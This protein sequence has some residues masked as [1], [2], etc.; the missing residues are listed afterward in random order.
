MKKYNFISGLPRSGS[1]L[2]S[3]ILNQNPRFTAG[4]SDPLQAYTHSIIRDTAASVGMSAAVPVEKRADIIRGLF[5]T[6]YKNDNEVCFN[7]NRGWAGD[8]HL[9]ADLFPNFK[10]IVCLRDVPW[11]LDSFEVLNSKNPYTIK[12]LYHHIDTANV[13][14]RTNIL[15]G[16]VPN[17]AGYVSGPVFNARASMFSAQKNQICYVEYDNLAKNPL[18]TMKQIYEF[19]EEPWFE[20]DFNNVEVSYDEYDEQTNIKGLHTIRKKVEYIERKT[21]LPDDIWASHNSATFWKNN[22]DKSGLN[23]VGES[24]KYESQTVPVKPKI[25]QSYR[26]L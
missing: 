25:P 17:L 23:W 5:D 4:I 22:F 13:Y 7:T 20:H 3:S 14:E 19:L 16:A 1:T 11:V 26:Q 2:L 21:I 6:F 18:T 24:T 15:M 10:M 9:L 8:T 12:A